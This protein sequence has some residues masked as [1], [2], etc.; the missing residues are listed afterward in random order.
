MT[1]IGKRIPKL[2]AAEKATGRARY[3][4]DLRLPGM[5]TGRIK[6][7]TVASG[8]VVSIDISAALAVPGV[9][10]VITA[11]D[12][13]TTRYGYEKD[14]TALKGEFVRRGRRGARADPR[15]DRAAPFR[16]RPRAG[17]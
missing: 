3:V 12:A 2:D 13:P 11:K 4:Q 17:A 9:V 5:L 14:T 16:V 8:R 6:R 10:A 7:S 1:L 15:R